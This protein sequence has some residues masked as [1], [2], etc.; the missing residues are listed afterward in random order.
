MRPF[1]ILAA[2]NTYM[3]CVQSSSSRLSLAESNP[4][5]KLASDLDKPRRLAVLSRSEAETFLADK[6]LSMLWGV[7]TAMRQRLAGD[8]ITSIRQL[9][10]PRRARARCSLWA[11]WRSD[12]SSRTRRGP[13][14]ADPRTPAH[15]ILAETTLSHD[16]A[17][18]PVLAHALW[19]LCERQSARLKQASLAGRAISW[20]LKTANFRVRTRSRLLADPTQLAGAL[21]RTAVALLAGEAHGV[22]RF[23]LIGVG[24]EGQVADP[25]TLFDREL[26][27]ARR[28]EHAGS[29]SHQARRSLSAARPR[30]C[31]Q[32]DAVP[33]HPNAAKEVDRRSD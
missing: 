16:E 29:N 2:P 32:Q 10:H 25:P 17:D 33:R 7:G 22:I 1:S 18:A 21:F 27:R 23:R 11:D 30:T 28:L 31:R 26:G 12:G 13:A 20:K 24:S 14:P 9:R 3:S 5:A 6:P 8:G 19:R 4:S 15:S